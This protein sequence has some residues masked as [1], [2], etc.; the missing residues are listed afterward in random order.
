MSEKRIIPPDWE[1]KIKWNVKLFRF[2]NSKRSKLLDRFYKYFFRL[3]KSY[4]LPIFLP[5]FYYTGGL[6]SFLHLFISL[7]ITGVLM[8][9][10][11]YTFRHQR[12]SKLMDNVYL[13]EPVTLKSFPSADAAYAFTLLGVIIFYGN[14]YVVLIFLVYALLIGYGRVYMGAHFPIDVIVGSI[15]GLFSGITGA[16]LTDI[17]KE[18]LNGYF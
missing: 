7:F 14:L 4:T 11:K 12:P 16:Y 13:L 8:P 10:I 17:V 2:I 15:I 3:G 5:F 18:I 1:L 9:L 6:K